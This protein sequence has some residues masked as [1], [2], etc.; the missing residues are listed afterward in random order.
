M[1]DLPEDDEYE[2]RFAGVEKIYGDEAFRQ[3]EHS[4]VMVIG[5]GGVGS[6]AVEALARTGIGELTIIDMDVVAASN[7][8][9]QL[10]AMSSTLGREKIEVMAERC[11]S[12]NPRVK[13]NVVDDYLTPDNVKELLENKPD[14]VLDCIDD[15]KA[16]LAL[17]LH[18]R[19]NKIPLIVS[20]GA[21]G[22]LD[23]LKI[24][25]ADLSKT[26]QDPM[27]A[28]LRSQLRAKGICKKP[29]EKF[30]IT[31][32]YSIDNPFSSADVCPSAGLRCGGYG[33]AVVV[34]S[35][36]AMVAVS[37]VLKKL[38]VKKAKTEASKS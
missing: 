25:V 36:F 30:G 5:I 3:Y 8:N 13:I 24:R 38:T 2:R 11:H 1:T 14:V 10:P 18:C 7:I 32:V 19:F 21:G 20:G 22:K 33:S 9:R 16:K 27:L 35:S 4:H 29:K 26:E 6:W 23:P 28:K 34:T 37:E 17:M 31:C 15:V 12:I